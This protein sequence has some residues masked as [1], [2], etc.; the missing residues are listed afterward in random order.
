MRKYLTIGMAGHIDHGKT[1]LTKALTGVDTDRLKEEKERNISIEP[2]F[3]P[4]IDEE[5]LNVSIIDVP[6]HERFIR[7]MI[8][9]V[10]GIDMVVLVI[11]ADEGV[12]P[13]TKEHLDILSLLGI[14][15]GFVVITKIDQVD[16][17]LLEIVIEDVKETVSQTFFEDTPIYLVD[18]LSKEGIPALKSALKEKLLHITKKDRNTA[19]RLPIDQVFTVKGQG[20]VVRGT[21]YDGKVKQG[22]HLKILPLN[23]D[24]RVRQIQSHHQQKKEA[25]AGQRTAI[26]IGGV[27]HKSISRG[28]VLV[29]GN[30]YAISDRLDV[31]FY[32]LK[33]ITYDV[34]QRQPI[35]LFIGT[36]EVM[37]KIIFFDRNEIS[38]NEQSEILCQI[39]LNEQVVVSRSDRFILRKPTPVETIGGGWVIEP[40]ANKHRFG[41]KTIDQLLLKKEGS[42]K[43]RIESLMKERLVLTRAEILKYASI[44]EQELVEAQPN[45]IEIEKGLVTLPS[46]FEHAKDI[47]IDL[48]ESFHK[49]LP[50]RIGIN[51]AEIISELKQQYPISL[52]EFVINRLTEKNNIKVIDQYVALHD[53][54][55]S[56]PPQWK[57]KLENAEEALKQQGMEVEKW[58]ELLAKHQIPSELQKEFYH[59]LIESERAYALDNERLIGKE[60]TDQ[61][62][63]RLEQHTNE[64]AFNLQTARDSLQLSRKNLLPLLELFDY[65]GYT[66]REGNLRTWIRKMKN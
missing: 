41:K 59:F 22:E 56:L 55:P 48:L 38:A 30:F 7:Q 11:A 61:A 4:F 47:L 35:K 32:S 63:K 40:E 51:K 58:S 5:Q 45:L 21:I 2:G 50:M 43:D 39:Q 13:Q 15:N 12:M 57:E 42:T 20:V 16:E 46:T 33:D 44:T 9:G 19:F 25:S 26:N 28:D 17:E 64:E 18:S 6:G 37:G 34:K 66:K 27:S 60:A 36:S 23:K 8:A 49:R 53:V 29:A 31:V 24:V 1:V 3:A 65:L 62:R 52:I 14:E 10:A 54:H